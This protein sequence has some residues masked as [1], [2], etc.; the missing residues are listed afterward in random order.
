M[1]KVAVCDDEKSITDLICRR[2]QEYG[3]EHAI[4]F[5]VSAFSSAVKMLEQNEA[6]D[7]YFFDVQMPQLDGMKAAG[8]IRERQKQA[9]IVFISGFVQYAAKGYQVNAVRYVLKSQ[10]DEEFK[11]C[12]DAVIA[13][14][15]DTN[16]FEIKVGGKHIFLDCS[17]VEYIENDR[18]KVL[19]YMVNGTVHETY[20]KISEL[21]AKLHETGFIHCHAAYLVNAQ[22]IE[23]IEQG[24]FVLYS[25]KVIP[26]SRQRF[27]QAQ[28]EYYLKKT[29]F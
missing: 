28:R 2:I 21:A 16:V 12:M 14:I 4:E 23:A 19:I 25:G 9:V 17:E 22:M 24:G 13:R 8:I 27:L 15:K 26:I 3:A 1:I 6:Y 29:S 5:S 10:L 20:A 18:R 7:V 11:D